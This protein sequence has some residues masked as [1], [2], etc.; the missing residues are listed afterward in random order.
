MVIGNSSSGIIEAPAFRKPAINIGERQKGRI[1]AESVISCDPV[2]KD[3]LCSMKLALSE[4]FKCK[5]KRMT[6]PYGGGDVSG[7][8]LGTIKEFLEKDT[9]NLKKS[10]YD[11]T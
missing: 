2:Q 4:G 10:F 11:L 5:I 3:I 8:I 6:P 7:K 9:I 1:C